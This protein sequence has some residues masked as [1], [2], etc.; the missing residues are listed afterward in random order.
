[1]LA[2]LVTR[3]FSDPAWIFERKLDGVRC[4]AFRHGGELHLKSRNGHDITATWP[5]IARELAAERR[6]DFIIDGEIVAFE[7]RTT[8]FSRLQGRMGVRRPAPSLVEAIPAV[9]YVFD[10]LRLDGNDTRAL[11]QRERKHLLE[12]ALRFRDPVRYSDHRDTHGERYLE[13]ACRKGWEGLIA[14]RADAPYVSRR[15][16]DWLKFKCSAGQ[17]LVIGGYTDPRGSRSSFG[18]LLVG[19]YERGELHYAG[20]VGTGFDEKMLQRLGSMLKRRGR[21]TCPFRDTPREAGAHWVTPELVGQF[22]FTEWTRDG[23]LRHPSFLGLRSD[24]TALDVRRESPG[25]GA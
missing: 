12:H 15:S 20:K 19:Y 18:A 13:E 16:R 23:K 3:H 25:S 2:T 21:A 4:L 8:S 7:G 22:S 9:Y 10:V 5:E 11:A 17:E 1:M 24:K 14:K 6:S